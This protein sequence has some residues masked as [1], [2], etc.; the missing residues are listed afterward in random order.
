MTKVEKYWVN[1]EIG[2][3]NSVCANVNLFRLLGSLFD[4]L[5]DKKVLEI[6]FGSGADLFECKKRGADIYG[7]EL[8][9]VAISHIDFLDKKKISLSKC[10]TNPIPFIGFFDLIYSRD[11]FCYLTDD[12]ILF[13]FED[14]TRHLKRNAKFVL[15]F[16]EKDL[17]AKSHDYS[18]EFDFNLLINADKRK[19]HSEDNPIRYLSSQKIIKFAESFKLSCIGSKT[20]IQSYDLHERHLIGLSS[21]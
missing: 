2:T 3:R 8:N 14:L 11:T 12:E 13:A 18:D 10:G 1:R 9:P 4:S 17:Y 19:I 16:I 21:E 20:I 5:N 6:G 7:I 15:Q